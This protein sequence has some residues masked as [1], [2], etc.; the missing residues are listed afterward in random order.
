MV[1]LLGMGGI[2]KTSLSEALN[3]F[4]DKGIVD[5]ENEFKQLI[6]YYNGNSLALKIVA[7]KIQSLFGGD[8]FKFLDQGTVVF[9]DIW[10]LLDQ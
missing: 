4:K 2:G 9:G 1:L 10:E 7:T 6:E 8:V 5:L 3:I